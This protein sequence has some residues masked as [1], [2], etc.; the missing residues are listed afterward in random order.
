MPCCAFTGVVVGRHRGLFFVTKT[1][2]DMSPEEKVTI[3]V[4]RAQERFLQTVN[5]IGPGP[6]HSMLT[7]F[8]VDS[9]GANISELEQG[10]G[11]TVLMLYD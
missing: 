5:R 2:F 1:F 7:T 11:P 10:G 3:E 8:M 6:L 9:L 4:T